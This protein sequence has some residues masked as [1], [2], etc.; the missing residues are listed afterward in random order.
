MYFHPR[1]IYHTLVPLV[2]EA[3]R[4]VEET[5][6]YTQPI[7]VSTFRPHVQLQFHEIIAT[8]RRHEIRNPIILFSFETRDRVMAKIGAVE[9]IY[10]YRLPCAGVDLKQL[11]D[12]TTPVSASIGPTVFHQAQ[13]EFVDGTITQLKHGRRL[14][15]LNQSLIPLRTACVNML[16]GIGGTQTFET[17]LNL[18]NSQYLDNDEIE[19]LIYCLGK[20]EKCDGLYSGYYDVFLRTKSIMNNDPQT[21][22]FRPDKV[23]SEIDYVIKAFRTLQG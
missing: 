14:E 7:F 16:A 12:F 5:G 23:I 9:G 4:A 22:G 2:E 20:L 10:F 1:Y 6:N 21:A 18:V 8:L 15:L 17:L 3:H 13:R 19:E 11:I